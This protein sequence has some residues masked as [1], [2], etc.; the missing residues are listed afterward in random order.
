MILKIRLCSQF[1]IF[2]NKVSMK[3]GSTSNERKHTHAELT[4]GYGGCHFLHLSHLSAFS[5]KR[6]VVL[7]VF[8]LNAFNGYDHPL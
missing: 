3:V 8:G 1:V 4:P 2:I 7:I 6:R 5:F